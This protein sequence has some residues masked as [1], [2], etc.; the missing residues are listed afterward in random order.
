MTQKLTDIS[1]KILAVI[2]LTTLTACTANLEWF[3]RNI[4][5]KDVTITLRFNTKNEESRSDNLPLKT[6]SLAYKKE[7][8]KIDYSTKSSLKDSLE[9]IPVNHYTYQIIL[10]AGSTVELTQIIP[11]DF[12]Y[13]TN[14]L[15]EFEQEGIKYAIN[16][17]DIFEKHNS[18]K[19]TG[20][21][22]LK[23]LIYFDYRGEKKAVM[24]P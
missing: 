9:V 1:T 15:A 7:I 24:H 6:K 12:G 17:I 5:D 14:V 19:R 23:N 11:T 13:H 8:V 3:L 18:F 22:T 10:P 4:S 21:L 2:C 16:S 20:G